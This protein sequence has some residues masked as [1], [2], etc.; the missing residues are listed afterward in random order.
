MAIQGLPAGGFTNVGQIVGSNFL[1]FHPT[2]DIAGM[3][4]IYWP[5]IDRGD[6]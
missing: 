3:P 2:D 1:R 4:L 6:P 5:P